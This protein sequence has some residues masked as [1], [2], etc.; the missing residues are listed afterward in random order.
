MIH[1]VKQLTV[2][3]NDVISGKKTFEVRLNDRDYRVGDLVAL[4]EYDPENNKYTGR[5]CLVYIDYI[6]DDK[7]YCLPGYIVMS[8]KPCEVYEIG[9][10]QNKITGEIDYK[11]RL[12]TTGENNEQ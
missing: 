12:A 8:I 1:A 6:L 5:S 4:N 3:F 11:V 7:L 9:A 10:P 2:H